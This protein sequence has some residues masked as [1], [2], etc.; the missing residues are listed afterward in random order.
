MR[1][2]CSSRLAAAALLLLALGAGRAAAAT[3]ADGA[4]S[5]GKLKTTATGAVQ[6]MGNPFFVAGDTEYAWKTCSVGGWIEVPLRKC[7]IGTAWFNTS[8]SR[9]TAPVTG[10]YLFT[11]SMYNYSSGGGAGYN[12]F[13]IGV[14]GSPVSGGGRFGSSY[15]IFGSGSGEGTYNV[16]PVAIRILRLAAGDYASVFTHCNAAGPLYGYAAYSYFSGVLLQ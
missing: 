6:K 4:F 3:L 5:D 11:A 12:H 13:D 8:T 14:N 2:S 1:A 10:V 9:F 7:D 15:Q 16:S